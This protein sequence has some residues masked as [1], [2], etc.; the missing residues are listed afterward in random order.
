MRYCD[1]Y[2]IW[3]KCKARVGAHQGTTCVTTTVGASIAPAPDV[4]VLGMGILPRKWRV[5]R[6]CSL[7]IADARAIVASLSVKASMLQPINNIRL[8][9]KGAVRAVLCHIQYLT[10]IQSQGWRTPKDDM[11]DGNIGRSPCTGTGRVLGILRYK[12][13]VL[14]VQGAGSE[15]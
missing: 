11:C 13:R 6:L 4:C 2:N 7:P 14:R 9:C 15:G 8:G 3:H 1:T 12:Q 10:R 5:V